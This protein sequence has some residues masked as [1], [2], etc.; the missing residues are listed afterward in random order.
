[1]LSTINWT[2]RNIFSG[3]SDNRFDDVFGSLAN[4]AIAVV[5][6]S[7]AEWQRVIG[8]FNYGGGPD[9]YNVTVQ[10]AA[11]P[12]T[13]GSGVGA[14]ASNIAFTN[15]K[16]S[17]ADITINYRAIANSGNTSSGWWLD[18]SPMDNS[19]FTGINANTSAWVGLPTAALG[20]ADL[21]TGMLHEL[22][23]SMG[24]F[25]NSTINA[26]A[27]DTGVVD[28]VN[29]P[30]SSP[31]S[32]IWRFDSPNVHSL[33]TAW[34]STGG[35][36]MAGTNANGAQ[37][38][39]PAGIAPI[40]QNNRTYYAFT[41]LMNASF[42]SR[43]IITDTHAQMLQDAYGYTI[44]NPS[45]F[46][47]FYDRLDANGVLT[48]STPGNGPDTVELQVIGGNIVVSMSLGAPNIGPD[49]TGT[50]TS[51]FP[52]Q[53]VTSINISTGGDSDVVTIHPI[54]NSIPIALNMGVRAGVDDLNVWGGAG[55]DSINVNSPSLVS[56]G[57]TLTSF[58]GVNTLNLYLNGGDAD[59][60]LP[61]GGGATIASINGLGGGEFIHLHSLDLF[62][63]L[64]IYGN[65][66]D[67][68]ITI[69]PLGGTTLVQPQVT[70]FGNDGNDT[71]LLGSNDTDLYN[72][73]VTFDGGALLAP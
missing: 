66:G 37:H 67:D 32:E 18:P 25:S 63:P 13:T 51:F 30:A 40:F 60:Y 12:L 5:D 20:G 47:T 7:I 48:I 2:N 43:S 6:A 45:T 3:S 10:M 70:V 55:Y 53:S 23:H 34:N 8:S 62:V 26:F 56:T 27:T 24:L 9:T 69:D 15:G 50:F 71:L 35:T 59:V 41:D 17:S 57:I 46:G 28:T 21:L 36:G 64:S 68:T 54:Y 61:N 4:Q 42:T 44:V 73:E 22:G 65:G 39:A 38:A 49:P 11:A 14:G 72:A 58:T 31:A 16:P 1:M 19:E 33:W 29:A 52:S